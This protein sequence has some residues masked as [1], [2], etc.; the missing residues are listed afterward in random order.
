[1]ATLTNLG[2]AV[3]IIY[4]VFMCFVYRRYKESQNTLKTEFKTPRHQLLVDIDEIGILS[5]K[6]RL[7]FHEL[8]QLLY[9]W[10]G[11]ACEFS[12]ASD[13]E[14][15]KLAEDQRAF[16][17]HDISLQTPVNKPLESHKN[18]EK[19]PINSSNMPEMRER[20]TKGHLISKYSTFLE[21]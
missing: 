11:K 21:D 1:L 19:N 15:V 5:L 2:V 10:F 12:C 14:Q 7:S 16:E 4:G 8:D 13:I 3:L 17:S 20:S 18:P 9:E 6:D